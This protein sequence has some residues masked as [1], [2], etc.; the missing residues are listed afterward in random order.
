M[1]LPRWR[2]NETIWQKG[3]VFLIECPAPAEW[4]FTGT[5]DLSQVGKKPLLA[6]EGYSSLAN[7]VEGFEGRSEENGHRNTSRNGSFTGCHG[8]RA[9]EPE[10]PYGAAPNANTRGFTGPLATSRLVPIWHE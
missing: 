5:P 2:P 9:Y 7:V 6:A 3:N 1:D 4:H 10:R 8:R